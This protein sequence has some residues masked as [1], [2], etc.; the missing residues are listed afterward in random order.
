MF[1]QFTE[2]SMTLKHGESTY[3]S[4]TQKALIQLTNSLVVF[5][6]Y[7]ASLAHAAL[8]TTL[9][10]HHWHYTYGTKSRGCKMQKRNAAQS[11]KHPSCDK[12][13]FTTKN[14]L[15]SQVFFFQKPELCAVQF[16]HH[17][18]LTLPDLFKIYTLRCTFLMLQ[19]LKMPKFWCYAY[20]SDTFCSCS[21]FCNL[22]NHINA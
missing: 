8:P 5:I 1:L 15:I 2:G 4:S 20:L 19:V 21:Y 9:L 12:Y 11:S 6:V 17:L 10:G 16:N 7:E 18:C 22:F 3:Y 13:C 14:T